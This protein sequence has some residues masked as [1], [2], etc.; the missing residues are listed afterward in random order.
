MNVVL[1]A[2]GRGTR[3]AEETELRPKPLIEIGGRPI[4]QH[5]MHHFA[6]YGHR[7]FLVALGYRGDLIKRFFLEQRL[8][9]GDLRIDLATGEA[10]ARN[11]QPLEWVVDLIDTGADTATAGRL[12]R[13]AGQL[14]DEPFLMT[15]GDGV[16]D[17]DLAALLRFHRQHGRLATVTA[18]RP[19]ARF[20]RLDLDGPR[21]AR[22]SEKPQTDEG[23]INGGFFVLQPE[24]LRYIDGDAISFEREP[25]ER[26]ARD[27]E[28]MAFRHAGFW[29]CMDT[30]RDLRL[31]ESLWQSGAAPWKWE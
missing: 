20:G 18:V 28:L 29:Q 17:V 6:R 9:Q 21:V 27:G 2:G 25:L 16:S 7:R 11:G 23:W 5:I 14:R 19:P 10:H 1:L 13:L 22:F 30:L 12:K 31:L 3:L 24:V 4:L 15:Y 8:V 26:L